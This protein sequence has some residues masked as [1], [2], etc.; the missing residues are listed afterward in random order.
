MVF[1]EFTNVYA[2]LLL[3][4]DWQNMPQRTFDDAVEQG[5]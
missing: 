3:C 2:Y 4:E 5:V 1:P